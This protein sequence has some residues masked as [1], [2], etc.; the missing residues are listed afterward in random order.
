M[1][2]ISGKAAQLDLVIEKNADFSVQLT[3]TD[4][5]NALVDLTSYTADF[6][7]KDTDGNVIIN[8]TE[9]AGI[10]LGG[11]LGT[12]TLDIEDAVTGAYTFDCIDYR[13]LVTSP[14]D[15]VTRL[16]KGTVSL[17]VVF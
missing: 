2:T 13:L 12:I 3:W 1:A 8:L 7:A 11:A 4:E 5:N 15:F 10:T 14:T 9:L 16:T 6:T 17:D